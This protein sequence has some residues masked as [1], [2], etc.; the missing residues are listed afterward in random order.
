MLLTL[1]ELRKT[2][3]N[4]DRGDVAPF[5]AAYISSKTEQ[6]AYRHAQPEG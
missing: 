6:R 3:R 4:I 1:T 2:Q 5:T